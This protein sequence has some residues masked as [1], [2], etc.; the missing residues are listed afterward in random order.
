MIEN[1]KVWFQN[2][3]KSFFFIWASSL[4]LVWITTRNVRLA[5]GVL[6]LLCAAAITVRMAREVLIVSALTIVPLGLVFAGVD[7][8]ISMLIFF[9]ISLLLSGAVYLKLLPRFFS[10]SLYVPATFISLIIAET[11]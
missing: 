5:F 1:T 3:F 9:G 11:L 4:L 2:E 7:V 10:A 6:L 8:V